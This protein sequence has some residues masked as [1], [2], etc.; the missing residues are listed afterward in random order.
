MAGSSGSDTNA[1]TARSYDALP[2]TQPFRLT[3]AYQTRP[4]VSTRNTKRSRSPGQPRHHPYREI[5]SVVGDG[6]RIGVAYRVS[7][8]L[9]LVTGIDQGAGQNAAATGRS[10][11]GFLTLPPERAKC[12]QGRGF[13]LPLPSAPVNRR[14]CKW[15]MQDTSRGS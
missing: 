8:P 13:G 7:N 14:G 1:T 6:A 9:A 2:S 12:Y 5:L 11:I 15:L 3:R 10:R 4:T